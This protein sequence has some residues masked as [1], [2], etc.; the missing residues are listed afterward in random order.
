MQSVWRPTFEWSL[1]AASQ[2]SENSSAQHKEG[3]LRVLA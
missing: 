2:R 3:P 1:F